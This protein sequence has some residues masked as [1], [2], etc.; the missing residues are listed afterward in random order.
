MIEKSFLIWMNSQYFFSVNFFFPA[1]RDLIIWNWRIVCFETNIKFSAIPHDRFRYF[2]QQFNY[3][4]IFYEW[5]QRNGW[6]DLQ[7]LATIGLLSLPHQFW[8]HQWKKSSCSGNLRWGTRALEGGHPL[9][10]LHPALPLLPFTPSSPLLP[11]PA[12]GA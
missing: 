5:P 12:S 4:Q 3:F 9:P 10:L 6:V 2:F 8:T 1:F 11:G 7:L